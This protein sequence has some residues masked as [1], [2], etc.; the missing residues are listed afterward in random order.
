MINNQGLLRLLDLNTYVK[1]VITCY[2]NIFD[3]K[4]NMHNSQLGTH[5]HLQNLLNSVKCDKS[6]I[7]ITIQIQPK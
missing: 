6:E 3:F 1:N 7:E 5:L 4:T 2:E